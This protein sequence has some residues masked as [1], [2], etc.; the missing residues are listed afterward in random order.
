MNLNRLVEFEAISEWS[1]SFQ[2][3]SCSRASPA[4]RGPGRPRFE[5]RFLPLAKDRIVTLDCAELQLRRTT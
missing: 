1:G 4:E 2:S 3:A 5:R